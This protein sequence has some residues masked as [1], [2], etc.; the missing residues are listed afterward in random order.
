MREDP[1]NVQIVREP[2]VLTMVPPFFSVQPNADRGL[3]MDNLILQS[4]APSAAATMTAPSAVL[5]ATNAKLWL[6]NMRMMG[7]GQP[8]RALDMRSSYLYAQGAA[9]KS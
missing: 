8:V 3:W 7:S 1:Q 9:S 2:C 5:A 6:T 4:A